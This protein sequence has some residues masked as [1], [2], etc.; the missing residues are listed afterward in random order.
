MLITN[1][2]KQVPSIIII[3]L[4]IIIMLGKCKPQTGI[5]QNRHDTTTE[6][7]YVYIQDTGHSKPFFIRGQR[8]TFIE[9]SVQYIPSADYNILLQQFQDLKETLLSKNYFK[10][11]IPLDTF[12]YIKLNDTIQKN[13]F[14]GRGYTTKFHIPVKTTTITNTI[15]PPTKTQ[16]YF[17]GGI[18][19]DKSSFLQ[20]LNLGLMLKTKRDILLGANGGYDF[21]THQW[22]F[23]INSYWKIKL[24]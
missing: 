12:G 21:N 2:L 7:H 22:I 24:K 6:I 20:Q 4:L 14:A 10:D 3:I 8:D 15:H 23:G 5:S 11:S 13:M 1:I 16:L 17:G 9:S 18:V 19:G